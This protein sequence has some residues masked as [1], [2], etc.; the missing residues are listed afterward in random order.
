MAEDH[1]SLS[2][3]AWTG[4]ESPKTA[5]APNWMKWGARRDLAEIKQFLP[6]APPADLRNWQSPLVGWGLVLPDDDGVSAADKALGK[7]AEE[8]FQRLLAARPDS[9]V[10]RYRKDGLGV[11]LRRYYTDGSDPDL[12]MTLAPRGT[13]KNRLPWYLLIGTSPQAIPWQFQ[14]QLNTNA[15]T[16]RL[17]LEGEALDN[18]VN[19]LINGWPGSPCAIDQPLVWTVDFGQDDIT[20]LMRQVIADPVSAQLAN[21][22]AIGDKLRKL[23]SGA[24]TWTNLID[25]LTDR[26][27]AFILSTSH[28]M[29]GPLDNP[30]LMQQNLGIPVD[31]EK[32]IRPPSE[33]L[34]KW[35]P[36]GAIW[37]AHACCS[38]G[39][40]GRTAYKGLVPEGST[41]ENLLLGVAGLGA[42][43]APLPKALLGAQ[44]PL[45]AFIGH[46]EPTFDWTLR[47]P[48]NRAVYTSSLRQALYDR[49]HQQP[50]EPIGMAFREFFRE[51][52][53]LFQAFEAVR[54]KT[55]EVDPEKR[56]V[57]ERAAA[58]IKLNAL[59]RQSFVIL[60]DPTVALP[61]FTN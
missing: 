7:D 40:D 8:P 58:R 57:A 17:D 37:Y 45:R 26:K 11:S 25:T 31:V 49:M 60:G 52:G 27:P 23:T 16:G 3:N 46:V 43:V 1:V 5:V 18:Y 14:Y 21:D 55:I 35:E 51:V 59:D 50:P 39:C 34:N 10:L 33:L 2:L 56:G 12:Q 61:P 42:Q 48:E 44:K 53:S 24:A 28:G 19:A 20:W 38:A 22:N 54:E 6:A 41:V 13:G 47:D 29:T 15:F 9:P 32:Q 4:E 30:S 36:N